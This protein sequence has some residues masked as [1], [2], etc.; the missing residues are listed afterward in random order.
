MTAAVIQLSDRVHE[1]EKAEPRMEVFAYLHE[2]DRHIQAAWECNKSGD[3]H[4]VARELKA[5]HQMNVIGYERA[6]ELTRE[7]AKWEGDPA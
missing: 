3:V 2:S 1:Q 7:V 5:M 4:G 6:D